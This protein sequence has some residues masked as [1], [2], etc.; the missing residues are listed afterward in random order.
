MG[1]QEL[2]E[3]VTRFL[4]EEIGFYFQDHEKKPLPRQ[5]REMVALGSYYRFV[6][7]QYVKH[8]LYRRSFDGDVL[9]FIPPTLLVRL[10]EDLNPEDAIDMV[11]DKMRFTNLMREAGLPVA[12]ILACVRQDTAI[13]NATGEKLTLEQLMAIVDERGLHELFLKPIA[14]AL[15]TGALKVEVTR[16]GFRSAGEWRAPEHVLH[17]L[18]TKNT[19]AYLVQPALR[20]HEILERICPTS[21]NTVR[22]D[23]LAIGD[24]VEHSGAVLRVGSGSFTDN[25]AGGGLIVKI[26]LATGRLNGTGK[27]KAQ[28]GRK[29]YEKHPI[30]GVRFAGAQLPFWPEVKQIVAEGARILHPLKALGW[31]VAICPRGPVL[32]EANHDYDLVLHQEGVGGLRKTPFGRE[33]LSILGRPPLA[34]TPTP[35]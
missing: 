19:A 32:L 3:K 27:T 33:L 26:D 30:T 17:E 14:G 22:I 29:A 4:R 20:Q 6:P 13:T 11:V 16:G 8:G 15:G 28:Y 25:W 18:V 35:T 34:S 9:D 10:Q 2:K 21:I 24:Q 31:D 5:L 1:W 23:T 7:Y 12:E